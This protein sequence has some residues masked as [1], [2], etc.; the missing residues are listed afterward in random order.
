MPGGPVSV[1]E[2]KEFS[3]ILSCY[4]NTLDLHVTEI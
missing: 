2:R 4:I 1:H 3:G